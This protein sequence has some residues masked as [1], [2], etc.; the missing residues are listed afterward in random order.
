MKKVLHV[1]SSPRGEAS[2]SI[3]L[4]NAIIE[5]IKETY[6]GS[7]VKERNLIKNLFPHLEQAQISSFFTP[8]ESLSPEQQVAI[9]ISD[10]AIAELQEADI[11][12]IGAP[13]Y[14]FTIPSTLN[15]YF[16]HI[17]RPGVTFRYTENGPEG[18]L[19][20]KKVY[21]ATSSGGV[22]SEG[23]MQAYDFVVPYAQKFLA[24]IG[25][26]DVTV[27]RVEGLNVPQ[28]K[29]TALENGLKSIA[30]A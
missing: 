26:T 22:Y 12:V 20:N 24:F 10:E 13:M 2:V 3:K 21:I 4:G 9:K 1:I 7:I 11:I 14:S 23:P 19:K 28:L 17:A 5:K 16:D 30:I 25:I 8:A 6:P 18:F 29:D 15:A 27:I